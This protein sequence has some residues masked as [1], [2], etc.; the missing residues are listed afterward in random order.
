MEKILHV[1]AGR[2]LVYF[3]AARSHS[4]ERH[5]YSVP[6]AGGE[7]RPLVNDS[8]PAVWS[9]SFSP[10]GGYYI[11]DYQGPEQIKK[12]LHAV[13][14]DDD[15]DAK[16][17]P[18]RTLDVLSIDEMM[19]GTR[20]PR[21]SYLELRHPD[22]HTLNVRQLL[23]YD[24]DPNKR[25]PVLF[26][27]YGGPGSQ[28][29]VKRRQSPGWTAEMTTMPELHYVIYVVDGRGTG[30]QGR[31]FR[32]AVS[33]QLGQLEADDQ[34]WAAQQLLEQN[35]FLNRDHVGIYGHSFGGY[36]AAKVVERNSGLFTFG[37]SEAAVTDWRLYDSIYTERFMKT[38]EAN[39]EGYAQAAVR[40]AA[41]FSNLAGVFCFVHGTADDNVHYQHAAALADVLVGGGVRPDKFAMVALTDSDHSFSGKGAISFAREFRTARLWDELQRQ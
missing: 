6:L 2:G 10:G 20:R 3:T 34:I 24:F 22:G 8:E 35:A 12:Q 25:Y 26:N 16:A 18:L 1:D 23:P 39:P 40:N 17:Y 36:L 4:T 32:A 13:V 5:V 38:P 31:S 41:G 7:V 30:F 14:V 19:S 11:L 37:I 15:D 27:P 21:V 33:G 28:Q 29:V 9:A